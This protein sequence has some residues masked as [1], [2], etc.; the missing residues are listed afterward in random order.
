M[1][2][3]L[4][5]SAIITKRN[6]IKLKR[7]PDLLFFATLSPIM[8]VLLFA[9]VF[10]SAIDVP[11]I[12]YK[13]F[14]MG[15]IFVQTMIFGASLTG[16][17]LAEDL[18]K[19]VMDR[20]RSL[21]MARSAVVIGRTAADVGNNLVTITIMSLTGLLVGWR[22]TSSFFD[23]LLGYVLLLLFAYS[24]SWVMALVGLIVRSPEIFNNASFIVIFP[25]TFIANTFVPIDN[26]PAVLKTIA[27][28]NPISS[29]TLAVREQFGNTNPMAPP[30][31]VWPLQNPVLYTLIWVVLMLVV[32]VPLSV[33]KYQKTMTA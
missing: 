4:L 21:P 1:S 30:P 24:I 9:Y 23:A 5:D 15:G 31:E 29:V 33:R 13:S 2:N 7:V 18:Q 20:F 26:F 11:G 14:L 12:D 28:W 22:I 3:V 19:G 25:L 10:G 16:S 32:F 6:L 8:F 17:S 27:E